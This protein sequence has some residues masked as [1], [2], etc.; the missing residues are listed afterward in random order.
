MSERA[1]SYTDFTTA[2]SGAALDN[3]DRKTL[4][5]VLNIYNWVLPREPRSAADLLGL[6]K[7]RWHSNEN[8]RSFPFA[9]SEVEEA[10]HRYVRARDAVLNPNAEGDNVL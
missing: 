8:R 6:L 5:E 4:A 3:L 2:I 7:A 9:K 1:F 10:W